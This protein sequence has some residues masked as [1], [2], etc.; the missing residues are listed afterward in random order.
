MSRDVRADFDQ[1]AVLPRGSWDYEVHYHDFLL[2][3]L[4]ARPRSALEIGCGTGA[5]SRKLAQRCE[6]VH[7]IDLSPE[8]IRVARERSQDVPNLTFEVAD[9]NEFDLGRGRYDCLTSLALLHF[10]PLAPLLE[11]LGE[12]LAPG[13]SLAMLD[14]Y[15]YDGGVDQLSK[16]ISF[17]Y[18]KWLR[19]INTGRPLP[20]REMSRLWQQKY[21]HPETVLTF[22]QVEQAVTVLRGVRLR[23]HLLRRYSIVWKKPL[24]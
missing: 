19:L 15:R 4:P 12:A 10:F 24:S 18:G 2:R 3:Q 11:R 21:R 16:V 8:S 9:L 14:T 7:A 23:R 6:R 17:F 20:N 22:A 5:F 13:G 1:L